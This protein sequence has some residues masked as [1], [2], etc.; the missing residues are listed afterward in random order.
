MPDYPPS[1]LLSAVRSV[2]GEV[3]LPG[4][5][6]ISNRTLL[7]AALSQGTT[8]L[9][10]LLA[11]DD[12]ERMLDALALLGV[13]VVRLESIDGQP[14]VQVVGCGGHWPVRRAELYLGNAGTAYRPLTAVLAFGSDRDTCYRLSGVPR[15]HERPVGDLVDALRSL[16][17]P[18]RY[19]GQ[20]GYPPLEI[21]GEPIGQARS[22]VVNAASVRVR[23]SVSSQFLT[24]L[25]MAAPLGGRALQIELEGELISRPYIDITVNM[26]ARF[27]VTVER[28]GADRFVVPATACYQSPGRLAVEGDASAASYFLAAGAIAGGPVRVL[29]VGQASIQGDVGFVDLLRAMGAQVSLGSDWIEVTRGSQP[30]RAFD[31]D[32]ND[33]PDA[34]MTAAMLALFADRPSTLRNIGSWRVKE[35]DRI[36]AM[37][38]ELAKLGATVE[39]GPDWLRVG[40]PREWR[41]AAIDTYD[42]HRMA[43]CFSL[44]A[45]AGIAVTINEPDCVAKTYPDYFEHFA[46]LVSE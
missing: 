1:L 41:A 15:M 13:Q 30:L 3:R 33:I 12:T 24:A 6:S 9:T 23:G 11:S 20:K 21:G 46:R 34:A 35:T 37:A 39:S 31:R 43:M 32:F 26:M 8:E 27:G 4:S 14:R 38:T 42:D 5:K 18:I 25:L 45:L 29:G 17:Y 7:L 28:A 22:A 19:L 40:P 44:A 10:G 36:A 2:R 16:G